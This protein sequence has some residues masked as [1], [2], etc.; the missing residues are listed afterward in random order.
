MLLAWRAYLDVM[1]GVIEKFAGWDVTASAVSEM[2]SNLRPGQA[3]GQ[4]DKRQIV[5]DSA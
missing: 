1:R 5:R 2:A 4:A 3:S